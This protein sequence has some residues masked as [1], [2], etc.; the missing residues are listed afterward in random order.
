MPL[1]DDRSAKRTAAG[2]RFGLIFAGLLAFS[3]VFGTAALQPA[4]AAD[5]ITVVMSSYG[6]LYLPVLTAKPARSR[7][8]RMASPLRPR[9]RKALVFGRRGQAFPITSISRF[10]P[11]TSASRASRR[12]AE[13]ALSVNRSGRWRTAAASP[14]TYISP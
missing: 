9:I 7:E 8:A 4:R 2:K 5:K 6:F 1:H 10:Q 14:I 12:A 13:A 11:R 3:G